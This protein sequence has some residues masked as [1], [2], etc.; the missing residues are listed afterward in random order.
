[1]ASKSAWGIIAP[2]ASTCAAD[3]IRALRAIMT[4]RIITCVGG[5]GVFFAKLQ[6]RRQIGNI[7][8]NFLL[9]GYFLKGKIAKLQ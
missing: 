6:N 4:L 5:Y 7:N 1:M 2:I 8:D 3:V 9:Q